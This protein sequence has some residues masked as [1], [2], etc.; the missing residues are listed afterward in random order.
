MVMRA[1]G[2]MGATGVRFVKVRVGAFGADG[3][4]NGL[5]REGKIAGGPLEQAAWVYRMEPEVDELGSFGTW[6]GGAGAGGGGST[7]AAGR[8]DKVRYAVRQVVDAEWKRE[9]ARLAGQARLRRR[10][11]AGDGDEQ[12]GSLAGLDADG[13]LR[14][15]GKQVDELKGSLIGR[16]ATVAAVKKDFFGRP[17]KDTNTELGEDGSMAHDAHDPQKK[18]RVAGGSRGSKA[19]GRVWVSFHEGY[20]NAVRKPITLAELMAGF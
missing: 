1:V 20:S 14:N 13:K 11:L 17:L 10:G 5:G 6:A 15:S 19:Q 18:R 7:G 16:T 9:S 3:D 8:T 4:D 12:Q 2:C